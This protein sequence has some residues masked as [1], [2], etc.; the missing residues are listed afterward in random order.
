MSKPK[1]CLLLIVIT[2]LVKIS[3][4]LWSYSKEIIVLLYPK[5]MQPLLNPLNPVATVYLLLGVLVYVT[6]MINYIIFSQTIELS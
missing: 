6:C 2:F 5:D 4:S 3:T 1:H